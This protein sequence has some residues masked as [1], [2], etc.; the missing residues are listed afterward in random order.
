LTKP[1]SCIESLSS[2]VELVGVNNAHVRRRNIKYSSVS[3]KLHI[4]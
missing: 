4:Y 1:L 2:N 3:K